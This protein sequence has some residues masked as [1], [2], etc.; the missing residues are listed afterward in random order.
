M[1]RIY[2]ETS[3]AS[4]YFEVRTDPK[5]VARREWTRRWYDAAIAG[6]DEIV[7]S[8]A[9]IAELNDGEYESKADAL[10]LFA[11]LPLLALNNDVI[12]V[13]NAYLVRKM[14]PQDPGGDALHLAVASFH[15][16]DFLVTW[17]CQHLANANK[18]GNIRR[19]NDIL[20][21]GNPNLVTPMELLGESF[22]DA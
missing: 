5:M 1:A 2:V 22:S 7:T 12:D 16:C 18:F 8:P 14:M 21:I 9:T 13:M 10:N 17:N 20:G 4:F 6:T 3:I 15:R 19:V 11:K